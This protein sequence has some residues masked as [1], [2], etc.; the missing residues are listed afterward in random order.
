LLKQKHYEPL[1]IKE[2]V[3]L[4]FAGMKGYLEPVAVSAIV[5]FKEFLVKFIGQ[6]QTSRSY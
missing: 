5:D 4:V 6:Y 2:E 1:S 3:I